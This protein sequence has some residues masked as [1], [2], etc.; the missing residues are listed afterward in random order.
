MVP[1]SVISRT[2][3]ALLSIEKRKLNR[4]IL[5]LSSE[6]VEDLS[7]RAGQ[8]FMLL[9]IKVEWE[10]ARDASSRINRIGKVS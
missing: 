1:E 5:A 2:R 9:Q 8:T 7:K 3:S 10:E 6:Q 4:T